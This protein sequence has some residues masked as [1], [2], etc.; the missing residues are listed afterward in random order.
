[1]PAGH[2]AEVAELFRDFRAASNL[3]ESDLAARLSTRLEVV[4]AL[5]QGALYALPPWAETCRVVNN[6]GLLLN[7]DVRPLLRRIYAQVEA[8]IVELRPKPIPEV[9]FMAPP[10]VGGPESPVDGRPPLAPR[11]APYPQPPRPN[12][13]PR[14]PVPD[15]MAD[16]GAQPRPP[17]TQAPQEVPQMQAPQMRAPQIRAPQIRAPQPQPPQ[18]RPTPPPVPAAV[19]AEKRPRPALLKW[20]VIALLVLGLGFGLWML[21]GKPSL[22]GQAP[23]HTG[24]KGVPDKPL[25]PDDP[26]NRK[27]DRLPSPNGL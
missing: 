15:R 23:S 7:L 25:D 9:P 1:M 24:S 22:F 21:L 26:R 6:Y 19:M 5:E 18:P 13:A 17:Q 20:G 2:D 4:Q 3:T 8:G 12:V 10:E 14:P 11:S 27:A 16:R